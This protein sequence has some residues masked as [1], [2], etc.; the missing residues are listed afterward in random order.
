MLTGTV[1]KIMTGLSNPN[2][3]EVRGVFQRVADHFKQPQKMLCCQGT[4][5]INVAVPMGV[6]KND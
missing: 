1:R 4:A 3:P 2:Q 5:E 6:S